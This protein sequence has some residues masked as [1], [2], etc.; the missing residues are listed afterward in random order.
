MR[1]GTSA[2]DGLRGGT[3]GPTASPSRTRL[4]LVVG[5]AAALLA[6]VIAAGAPAARGEDSKTV[7]LLAKVKSVADGGVSCEVSSKAGAC[8]LQATTATAVIKADG[9]VLH[10]LDGA[11]AKVLCRHVDAQRDPSTGQS[12]PPSYGQILAVVAGPFTP[13]SDT[14]GL[15]AGVKWYDGKIKS[16]GEKANSYLDGLQLA[17]GPV[18]PCWSMAPATPAD[19]KKGAALMVDGELRKEGKTKVLDAT[20]V[21]ILGPQVP[22][23]ELDLVLGP[24]S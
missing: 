6:G 2:A 12:Q 22:A 16:Q 13:P 23:A 4:G 5:V 11:T 3:D 14:S 24:Q 8:R 21:V 18:R 15:P 17:S 20:R 19:L 10:K 9:T 1:P 7:R